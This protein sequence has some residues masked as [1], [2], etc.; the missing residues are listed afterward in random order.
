MT[1]P[2]QSSPDN[3]LYQSFLRGAK[4]RP[5][6][7]KWHHYFDV[8]H[9]HFA[10]YRNRQPTV[11]EIG[12]QNGGSLHLWKEYFG[13]GAR[14][15]GLDIDPNC[16]NRGPEGATVFIGDQSDPAFMR[17]IL[18]KIGQPDIVIDDGGHTAKQMIVSFEAL[19]PAMRA[20]G[21]YLVEDTSTQFWGGGWVD[22][23]QGR[24]F[25]QYAMNISVGLYD[26]SRHLQNFSKLR[27]PPEARATPLPASELCKTTT[28][29][30]F[31]DGIVVF[32]REDRPEPWV[33]FR[34]QDPELPAILPSKSN[35][36]VATA[37][38]EI[39]HPL[40]PLV[41]PAYR[42]LVQRIS[43]L[44]KARNYLEIGVHNGSTIELIDCPT[45]GVDPA[46]VFQ[47]NP[48]GKKPLLHLY[49][50]TSDDFFRDHDPRRILGSE[51]DLAFLDGL[52]LFEFLL[53]DFI[54]TERVSATDGL[55]L[56][57]DCL[58]PSLEM[59]EREHRPELRRDQ[60]RK[61]WWTGDVWKVVNVLRKY[62][63][64]LRLMAVDVVPTGSVV[65]SNLDPGST[66]LRDRYND[67]MDEY[68]GTVMTEEMFEAYWQTN[69]PVDA[70][71]SLRTLREL[72]YWR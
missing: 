47:R 40:K 13:D 11:L 46:F 64:D 38:T 3:P 65:V 2:H 66:V 6:I 41:G 43:Q 8:Y 52:H 10:P 59:T 71:A 21:V 67:I 54:N 14:L 36:P 57:D 69:A 53:R 28:G 72:G 50:Q 60:S 18:E 61:G 33:E 12:V 68:L 58:P 15:F 23:P 55:I 39:V 32:T 48:M 70:N 19:Y 20:P 29:V 30:S 42:L 4:G 49:Q 26:W 62:R 63:P 44:K 24:S 25:I 37:M 35:G 34:T 16:A 31:H 9:R 22:D 1:P 51:V 7:D 5:P 56:M 45:I 17:S 27:T